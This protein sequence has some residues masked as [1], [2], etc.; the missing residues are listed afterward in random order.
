MPGLAIFLPS[1]KLPA[2]VCRNCGFWQRNF[3]QPADCPVCKDY[4]HILPP[5]GWSF[6]NFEEAREKFVMHWEETFPG[7]WHFWNDPVDGIGSHSYLI[8]RGEGNV[9]FEG[10]AVYSQS[11]LLHIASLGGV[12]FASASHPHTYGALWQLQDYFDANIAIH[13]AD[14]QWTNA[15]QVT[16][17]FDETFAFS[18]KCRLLH[19]GVHFHGQAFLSDDE[20][21][22]IFCGDA[23]KF[24]MEPAQVSCAKGI[25]AH[26]SFVRSIALTPKEIILY[27]AVFSQYK[28]KMVFSPF[29]QAH[30][31]DSE[32]V[33]KFF[34]CLNEKYPETRFINLNEFK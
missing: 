32:I 11:A 16:H 14:L 1:L 2:F 6:Y 17:P 27:Q 8:Q 23:M 4:R 31:V 3:T 26:K 10:A 12:Q 19:A 18:T 20:L 22:I 30:N 13:Q 21:G 15:F 9:I 25:S 33:D 28:F 29:E 7:L 24:D 5:D 34:I